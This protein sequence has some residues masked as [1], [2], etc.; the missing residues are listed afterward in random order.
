[1]L[2]WLYTLGL[3]LLRFVDPAWGWCGGCGDVDCE[4]CASEWGRS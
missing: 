4:D 2:G 3:R 1:M